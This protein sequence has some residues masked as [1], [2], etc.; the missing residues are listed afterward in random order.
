LKEITLTCNPRYRYPANRGREYNPKK[1]EKRLLEDTMKEFISYA[2]G[3]MFGRYSIDKDGLIL[4]NK[5]EGI[6]EYLEQI[7]EPTFMPDD[8]NAI[9]ILEME[10]FPDDIVERFKKFLRITFGEDHFRD[11]LRFIEDAIGKDIRKYFFKDFIMVHTQTYNKRPIY[12]LFSSPKKNFNVLIY[13]HRY[14]S[15]TPSVVLNSYLRP[16]KTKLEEKREYLKKVSTDET[17][18]KKDRI[19]AEKEIDKITNILK[20]LKD[21]EKNH[22]HPLAAERPD[23]DLDDGVK[24]NYAK[25]GKV[26]YPIT[27]LNK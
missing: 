8:D 16:Y 10:W 5:G 25:F 18:P 14:R 1:A 12:W 15:D 22:L 19:N 27:G 23:I 24:E 17:M 6:A 20:D 26:L 2:V 3:C 13:M 7:P 9:P 4:A 21:Y 11:N